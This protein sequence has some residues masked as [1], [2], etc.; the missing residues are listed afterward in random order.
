MGQNTGSFGTIAIPSMWSG[1]HL[2][3]HPPPFLPIDFSDF[4]LKR[5]WSIAL[6]FSNRE[7]PSALHE[8]GDFSCAEKKE[9]R[10]FETLSNKVTTG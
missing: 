1:G 2:E 5:E 10:N 7:S 8:N 4:R 3:K 9:K 6:A